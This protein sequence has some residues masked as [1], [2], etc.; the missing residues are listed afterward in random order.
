M[1]FIEFKK[2]KILTALIESEKFCG[3]NLIV[4][5]IEGRFVNVLVINARII[6]QYYVSSLNTP[7]WL[8]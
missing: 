2:F 5:N 4:E 7:D 3:T 6:K 1:N 8:R